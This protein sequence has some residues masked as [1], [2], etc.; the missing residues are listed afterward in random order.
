MT[1]SELR[2]GLPFKLIAR[3]VKSHQDVERDFV[4]LTRPEQLNVLADHRATAALDKLRA[5]GKTTAG[6]LSEY[7]K[8]DTA[9]RLT[10]TLTATQWRLF[11]ICTAVR[12]EDRGVT[13]F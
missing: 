8:D 11:P 7:A 13:G 6:C 10:S 2:K 1:L 3:H 12:S 9:P 4:D 5:E